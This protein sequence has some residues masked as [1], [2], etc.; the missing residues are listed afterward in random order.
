[1]LYRLVRP[2][3]RFWLA[4][5]YH[6][7]D[8]TGLRHIPPD[9]PVILAANHPTAFIEPCLLACFQPR[10]LHFLA[11]GDFF[12]HPVAAFL[13]RALHIL[14]VYR[15]Q[16]GGYE[17]LT[18]NY[19]TF[20]SCYAALRQRRALMILA[21]GRCIH[22]KRL[23]TL[24]KGTARVALGTLD[25]YPDLGEVY[26][27]PV[28]VN[29][30]AADRVRSAVMIRCG[31][32]LR[33]T[34]YLD[35]YRENEANGLRQL[36]EGLHEAL[37]ALV[38]QFPDPGQDALYETLLDVRAREVAQLHGITH[39]GR[40]LDRE[41]EVASAPLPD[42]PGILRYAARLHA[43]RLRDRDVAS[44]R[45]AGMPLAALPA[46]LAILPQFPLFLVAELLGLKVALHV[47]F[48]SPVRF[49]ALAVGSL[50]YVPAVV[51]LPWWAGAW[52]LVSL[53]TLSWS[54]RQLEAW[55]DWRGRRRF[56]QLPAAVRERTVALR[57][58]LLG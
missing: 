21:E 46:L 23:R 33:A 17:Q 15:L 24:R 50:A 42:E 4:R 56:A 9:A 51:L 58:E 57:R 53:L 54:L 10:S 47:E 34:D 1:M 32:P 49:A 28:G 45:R 7:V 30:T 19:D 29:F 6:N 39:A 12:R 22:E 13:L 14:P 38:V 36:T 43:L 44:N 8:L 3:A 48:Y 18:R 52:L 37:S 55:R 41:L 5:Y 35:A 26:I 20:E 40:Q 27:V 11:R 25:R 31:E 16:D 2:I